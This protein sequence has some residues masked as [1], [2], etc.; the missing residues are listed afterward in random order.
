MEANQSLQIL[1]V[2]HQAPQ[3]ITTCAQIPGAFS[4][5]REA[6]SEGA[7]AGA[8]LGVTLGAILPHI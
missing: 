5:G 8:I 7:A 3:D 1:E 6:V 4:M 2:Q